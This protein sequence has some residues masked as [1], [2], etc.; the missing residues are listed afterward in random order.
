MSSPRI[1][2]TEFPIFRSE[3]Q[4]D[5]LRNRMLRDVSP[6]AI[7]RIR[8]L[9]PFRA[10]APAASPLW[11]LHELH[12]LD[13]HRLL[14]ADCPT[15]ARLRSILEA[16]RHVVVTVPRLSHNGALVRS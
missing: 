8:E 14:L 16:V 7:A 3:K 1:G 6:E 11:Q 2:R 4:F 13:K 15:T 12:T 10:E 5:E 9:Q